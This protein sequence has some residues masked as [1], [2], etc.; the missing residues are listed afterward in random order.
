MAYSFYTFEVED[1]DG[2]D[3]TQRVFA[4]TERQARAI[5]CSRHDTQLGYEPGDAGNG[6]AIVRCTRLA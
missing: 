5:A 2:Y 6:P 1:S 4:P 3:S